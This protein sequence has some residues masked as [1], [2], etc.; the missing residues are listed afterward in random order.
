MTAAEAVALYHERWEEESA[1]DELKTHLACRA[2]PIRSKL[3]DLVVQELYGLLLA[4]RVLRQTMADAAA[5]TGVDPDRLSFVGT[6][7]ILECRLPEVLAAPAAV[8]YELLLQEVARQQLRPRRSRRY[9]RVV[10]KTVSPMPK[11]RVGL[12]MPPQPT[13]PFAQSVVMLI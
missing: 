2:V 13:K 8:W 12:P 7:R 11:K 6:L 9:P 10:K 3:P 4:H 1:L 5:T